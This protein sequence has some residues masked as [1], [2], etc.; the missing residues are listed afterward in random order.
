MN[1]QDFDQNTPL[2]M[3]SQAGKVD[4]LAYLIQET[5]VD[6]MVRNKFGYTPSDIAMNMETRQIIARLLKSMGI[7][8]P[9]STDQ[10]SG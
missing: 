7:E 8:M 6:A 10:S 4:T 3:A 9:K 1:V 5:K 2:H